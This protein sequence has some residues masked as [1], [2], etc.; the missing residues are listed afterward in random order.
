M[1]STCS[2]RSAA[3]RPDGGR[4]RVLLA[5]LLAPAAAAA[6]DAPA[7]EAAVAVDGMAFVPGSLR[8]RV[9]DRVTWTNA[10]IVPHTVTASD[11]S[12]DS[13]PLPPGGR[14]SWTARSRGTVP[15]GCTYH[16]SMVGTLVIG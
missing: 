12:F 3:D 4:R 13:G 2:R 14:W 7:V 15:Y 5:A 9:G 16:P 1:R 10:D 8:V 11:G 6:A